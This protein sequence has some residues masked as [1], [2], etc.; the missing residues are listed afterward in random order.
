MLG[1]DP[2]DLLLHV[3][4]WVHMGAHMEQQVLK[5]TIELTLALLGQRQYDVHS[6]HAICQCKPPAFS[7]NVTCAGWSASKV[8][9]TPH[10]AF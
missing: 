2:Q 7:T 8:P 3:C 5:T 10:S 4:T 6:S 1:S 9:C